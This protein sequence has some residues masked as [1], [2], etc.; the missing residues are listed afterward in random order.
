MKKIFEEGKGAQGYR[1]QKMSPKSSDASKAQL[2]GD[3][4]VPPNTGAGGV[5]T[6]EE[7]Q[8]LIKFYDVNKDGKL[9]EEEIAQ[10][11]ATVNASD[12]KPPEEVTRILKKFDVDGDGKLNEK[13]ISSFVK[14]VRSTDTKM[15]Y[16]GYTM[17][18]S[19][20]FRYL[21][22]TSDFG[23]ALRPVVSARIVNASYAVAIGYCFV[24]VG[25]E[26]YKLKQRNYITEKGQPMSMTQCVVERSAFQA[27]ASVAVPFLVIHTAVDVTKKMCQKIGKFQRWAPSVVGLA[28]IPLLPAYLDHPVENGLEH[29]FENYGPWAAKA[30]KD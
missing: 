7:L 8:V 26:A 11:I 4:K 18:F 28:C 25:W 1:Y 3:E 30:K 27:I 16:A 19:R 9:S 29:L 15:R 5:I 13:E 6:E 22:F 2:L 24:D 10:I 17:A 14:E 23:E 20:A 12:K 21:A